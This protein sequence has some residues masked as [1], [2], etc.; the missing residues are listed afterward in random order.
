MAYHRIHDVDIRICRIFNTYGPRIRK[1]DGRSV[2]NFINQ[3]INNSPITVYGDGKQTRSFCYVDDLI[4]G[5]YSLMVSDIN[6][7][8]NLGNP[9]EHTIKEIAELIKKLTKSKSKIIFEKLPIDDPRV[10][11]PDISKAKKELGWKPKIN[12]EEGLNKTID[13]FKKT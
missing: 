2:P 3:G 1:D 12:L 9:D 6:D 5:I 8:V 7:P 4:K 13:Y 10:R 11:R